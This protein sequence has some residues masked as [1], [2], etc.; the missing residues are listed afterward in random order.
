[1]FKQVIE[2][3][4]QILQKRKEK[5]NNDDLSQSFDDRV[6]ARKSEL[7]NW[8][9]ED[10]AGYAAVL[11]VVKHEQS[12]RAL[13]DSEENF[14]SGLAIEAFSDPT[15]WFGEPLLNML[16]EHGNQSAAKIIDAYNDKKRTQAK[17]AGKNGAS[18]RHQ[19]MDELKRY[20][21]GLYKQKKWNSANEAAFELQ[22][23]IINHGKTINANLKPSN[24]QRTIAEWFRKSV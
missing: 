17:T 5:S 14:D 22:Q 2:S 11:S 23:Q 12:A 19:P 13:R 6:E 10:L 21:V 1:M 8:S 4:Y 16:A 15:G 20:A 7:R 24:A 3:R 9:H 18:K